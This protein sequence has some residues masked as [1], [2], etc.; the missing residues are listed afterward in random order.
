M[1]AA[2]RHAYND[3]LRLARTNNVRV[4]GYGVAILGRQI[5]PFSNLVT[6]AGDQYYANMAI[7]GVQPA[8]ASAPTKVTGM[9]LGTGSTTP[10]KSGS[11]AALGTY[12]TGSN[13]AFDAAF[14]TASAVTGTDAGWQANYQTT[15]AAGTATNSAIAE[16]V[17]VTDS[18]TNAT[19]TAANT[20][21]RALLSPAADK[22]ASLPMT[23]LWHHVFLGA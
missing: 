17:I 4:F 14:P 10:L 7:T 13:A 3:G 22:T 18:A 20:I 21:A 6:T 15:W 12:I 11:A 5:I 1:H 23:I 19:S 8:N 16:A 9:K 2:L